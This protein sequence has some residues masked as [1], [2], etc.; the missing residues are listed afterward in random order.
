VLGHYWTGSDPCAAAIENMYRIMRVKG[1]KADEAEDAKA[2]QI[3]WD[4]L[5]AVMAELE[6][7]HGWEPVDGTT[8]Y[9]RDEEPSHKSMVLGE[10]SL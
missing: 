6:K 4:E 7:Q 9:T 10:L 1:G 5:C 8:F 3:K 2:R